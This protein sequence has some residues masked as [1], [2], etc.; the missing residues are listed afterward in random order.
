MH[1][2]PYVMRR[3]L[4]LR[5]LPKKK[6]QTV[7]TA[8]TMIAIN[9]ILQLINI[10]STAISY[11]NWTW[12]STA[13][14]IPMKTYSCWH[15]LVSLRRMVT[16]NPAGCMSIT[17]FLWNAVCRHH[18]TSGPGKTVPLTTFNMIITEKIGCGVFPVSSCLI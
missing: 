10:V 9:Q 12:R 7:H 5:Y 2:N 16:V 17:T 15:Q 13:V 6:V 14:W 11:P 18:C 1:I 4:K 3:I 8:V